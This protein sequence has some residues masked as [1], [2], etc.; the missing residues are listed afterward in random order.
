MLVK[1]IKVPN[2]FMDPQD[3]RVPRKF[4][5]QVLV[6]SRIPAAVKGYAHDVVAF[7]VVREAFSQSFN[8]F[9]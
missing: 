1:I 7:E 6:E 3:R 9:V 8:R 2:S 5:H 4:S